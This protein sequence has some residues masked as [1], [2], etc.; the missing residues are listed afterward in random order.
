MPTVAVS[1]LAWP[2]QISPF[3]LPLALCFVRHCFSSSLILLS[4][5]SISSAFSAV[6]ITLHRRSHLSLLSRL[7]LSVWLTGNRWM[8][9][10]AT[11]IGHLAFI[12]VSVRKI[13]SPFH[14]KPLFG[15][16]IV[17]FAAPTTTFLSLYRHLSLYP[18]DW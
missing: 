15:F 11:A 13:F 3:L 8:N 1:S 6:P 7:G 17:G 5:C 12:R 10:R 14:L 9:H 18:R 2:G 16:L 4:R